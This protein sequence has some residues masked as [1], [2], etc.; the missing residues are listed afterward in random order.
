MPQGLSDAHRRHLRSLS[1]LIGPTLSL[2]LVALLLSNGLTPTLLALIGFAMYLPASLF[3]LASESVLRTVAAKQ[4]IAQAVANNLVSLVIGPGALVGAV[5]AGAMVRRIPTGVIVL[6]TLLAVTAGL[7]G[8]ALAHGLGGGVGGPRRL[9][10]G[11]P[12]RSTPRS[13]GC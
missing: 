9:H 1:A 8:V 4:Q 10:D 2:G 11:P 6:V 5:I 3:S 7:I 13:A 12:R